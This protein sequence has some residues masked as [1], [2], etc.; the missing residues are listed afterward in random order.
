MPGRGIPQGAAMNSQQDNHSHALED[1][2]IVRE[3]LDR[4]KSRMTRVSITA[5]FLGLLAANFVYVLLFVVTDHLLPHGVPYHIQIAVLFL[6]LLGMAAGVILLVLLPVIRRISDTYA[7]RM[8][9][10]QNAIFRNSL[11]N[12]V[13]LDRHAELPGSVH[14]ALVARAA[15]D[16]QTV[17]VTRAVVLRRVR[18]AGLV[19]ACCILGMAGYSILAPKRVWPSVL[20]AF[21]S[22]M[23]SPTRTAI[24]NLEPADGFSVV[25]GKPV[26]FTVSLKGTVPAE[27][28]V[29]F[30]EAPHGPVVDG[31]RLILHPTTRVDRAGGTRWQATKSG[32][33]IQQTMFWRLTAG[34]AQS[35]WRRL[36]VRPYPDIAFLKI[37]LDHPPYTRIAQT[38]SSGADTGEI[39]AVVGTQAIIEAQT[40]VPVRTPVLVLKTEPGHGEELRFLMNHPDGVSNRI[41]G[42]MT[43][44]ENGR[45]WLRF[46]DLHGES[47]PNP[48]QHEIHARHDQPPKVVLDWPAG[49][50]A[51][52]PGDSL[53]IR[54]A[55]DDDYGISRIAIE[56]QIGNRTGSIR[57]DWPPGTTSRPSET[58]AALAYS[59][60]IAAFSAKAGDV[61]EW[62]LAAWDNRADSSN[63]PLPQKGMGPLR[64]IRV[65]ELPAMAKHVPDTNTEKPE[66][67][68]D[69]SSNKTSATKPAGSG[70]GNAPESKEKSDQQE[71]SASQPTG[72][73]DDEH[74]SAEDSRMADADNHNEKQEPLEQFLN[75]HREEIDKLQK[76]LAGNDRNGQA[77]NT[78][79]EGRDAK[80]AQSGDYA[81]QGDGTK[82][83]AEDGQKSKNAEAE[84]AMADSSRGNAGEASDNAD[85]DKAMTAG[86]PQSRQSPEQAATARNTSQSNKDAMNNDTPD[87]NADNDRTDV[88]KNDMENPATQPAENEGREPQSGTEPGQSGINRKPTPTPADSNQPE[89]ELK[90]P[91]IG[92]QQPS[93][94]EP[95]PE[96]SGQKENQGASQDQAQNAST[97]E[98]QNQSQA[99]SPQQSASGAQSG[100][101]PPENSPPNQSSEPSD[102]QAEAGGKPSESGSPSEAG[103]ESKT[104]QENAGMDGTEQANEGGQPSDQ[105]G[106]QSGQS[107]SQS[108]GAPK[109]S[110]NKDNSGATEQGKQS[111]ESDTAGNAPGA[112]LTPPKTGGKPEGQDQTQEPTEPAPTPPADPPQSMD[113]VG[114]ILKVIDALEQQLRKKEVD[115]ELLKE[116]GWDITQADRF[117][118]EYRRLARARDSEKGQT[119]MPSSQYETTI[120]RSTKTEAGKGTVADQSPLSASHR[121]KAD[122]T[123]QLMDTGRQNVPK[124]YRDVLKEY[125]RSISNGTTTAS[126][127]TR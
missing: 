106:T 91:E 18:Q 76:R 33:D 10:R 21:G 19:A 94:D 63:R 116:M 123:N 25:I 16:V 126:R 46:Q 115:P 9:E 43:I 41:V 13:Q 22:S 64:R 81:N 90:R 45:Y 49:D 65:Q 66:R 15:T 14:A 6:Y 31:Q 56:F 89:Q 60:P 32:A 103:Q 112:P 70:V 86:D 5:A 79:G 92:V 54:A 59:T 95:R 50:Q 11:I 83:D 78:A 20:R 48:I 35:A 17:S 82:T 107:S 42:R 118:R 124:E 110:S 51:A 117:V 71:Q 30:G 12:A 69:D 99:E 80:P 93:V 108:E 37:T 23:P 105:Q 67:D 73:N 111:G 113:S 87:P 120:R 100:A 44:N 62:R 104:G 84:S 98:Q 26:T 122:K 96:Q 24:S 114:D 68:D 127:P 28:C 72:Q 2:R 40:N 38:V 109:N 75:E 119:A 57:I 36:D 85:S 39:D 52:F 4:T 53:S 74:K 58:H 121:R 102:S 8:L 27:S 29:E 34:D 101:M 88:Q 55:V 1:A 77:Q 3:M 47:N 125:Y 97:A 7:A 61:I